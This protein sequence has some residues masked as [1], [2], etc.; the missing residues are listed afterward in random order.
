MSPIAHTGR[1]VTSAAL[2]LFLAFTAL[3]SIPISGTR[4]RFPVP[5]RRSTRPST[6]PPSGMAAAIA[7]LGSPA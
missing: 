4:N 1:L 3:A 5:N 6:Q 7:R 2:I